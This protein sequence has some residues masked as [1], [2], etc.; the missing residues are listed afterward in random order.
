[1]NGL[2]HR[3]PETISYP[4]GQS[5]FGVKKLQF[6]STLKI[7]EQLRDNF[8]YKLAYIRFKRLSVRWHQNIMY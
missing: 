3:D 6:F 5:C 8:L 4:I 7:H 2:Q 1:M